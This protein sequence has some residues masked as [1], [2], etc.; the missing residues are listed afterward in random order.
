M[1]HTNKAV[2]L[3]G[4]T[5]ALAGMASTASASELAASGPQADALQGSTTLVATMGAMNDA[6]TQVSDAGH[7][8]HNWLG[9]HH[10]HT[11]EFMGRGAMGGETGFDV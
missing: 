1:N 7:H 3:A 11:T 10:D 5:L 9:G 2:A 6:I 8:D 4:L